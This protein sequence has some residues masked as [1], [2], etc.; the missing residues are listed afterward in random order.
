[1]KNKL[2]RIFL[3]LF[4]FGLISC[5][6]NPKFEH[7]GIYII[8]KSGQIELKGFQFESW[9]DHY[10][11]SDVN[12][13]LTIEVKDFAKPLQIWVYSKKK[14]VEFVLLTDLKQSRGEYVCCFN[15]GSY[16]SNPKRVCKSIDL[17]EKPDQKEEYRL[18]E[19][20]I[21][22]GVYCFMDKDNRLGYIFKVD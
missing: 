10:Q 13:T 4:L 16:N 6:N 5:S 22:S 11:G 8:D 17:I 7:Y 18:F 19:A 2:F 21:E 14:T 1:M 12:N 9:Y 15:C 20:N 3:L